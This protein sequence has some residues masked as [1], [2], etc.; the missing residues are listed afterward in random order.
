MK[1][2]ETRIPDIHS[3][4]IDN[5]KLHL[6]NKIIENVQLLFN[7]EFLSRVKNIKNIKKEVEDKKIKVSKVKKELIELM[8]NYKRKKKMSNILSRVNEL[9]NLDLVLKDN[10]IKNEIVVLLKVMD[11][12]SNV[13]LDSY[14]SET[15]KI[16]GKR[17]AKIN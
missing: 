11:S 12:A 15:I 7:E 13:K 16:I 14:L 4:N 3:K 6:S 10:S 2:E 9:L 1:I 8:N 17:F 5:S